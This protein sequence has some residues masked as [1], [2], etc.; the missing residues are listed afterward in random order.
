MASNAPKSGVDS[1]FYIL[2]WTEPPSPSILYTYLGVP[3]NKGGIVASRK[4][5][6]KKL[7]CLLAQEI[8]HSM[9]RTIPPLF[10]GTP[11]HCQGDNPPSPPDVLFT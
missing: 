8:P 11:M 4:N 6:N 10:D 5:E 1:I 2:L 7:P 9:G 3:S